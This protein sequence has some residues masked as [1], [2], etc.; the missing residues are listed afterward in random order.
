MVKKMEAI[1]IIDLKKEYK[2]VK[3]LKNISFNI[4]ENELFGLLGVNGAGKTTLIKIL[5]G[6]ISFDEG[7]AYIYN[8]SVKTD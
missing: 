5:S 4:H 6:L 2:D 1:K 3:A 7:E 8:Y